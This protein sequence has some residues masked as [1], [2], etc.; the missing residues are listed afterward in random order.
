[1]AQNRLV[2][3]GAR[4][5]F[6]RRLGAR[7]AE[8][9][10]RNGMW[11]LPSASVDANGCLTFPELGTPIPEPNAIGLA[12]VRKIML[13]CDLHRRAGAIWTFEADAAT[14]EVGGIKLR[15][16]K[17]ADVAVAHEVFVERSYVFGMP[18]RFMFLDVGA[19]I[20]ASMLFLAKTYEAEVWGYE[21]VPSTAKIA[22][23]NLALNPE[24]A[25]HLVVHTYG[26]GESDME[27]E[28]ACDPNLR[29]SNSLFPSPGA[30]PPPVKS[31]ETISEKVIVKDV[32]PIVSEAL[33]KLGDRK[34]AVKLDAEGAEFGILRR[35]AA[36]DLLT[37]IDVLLLEWHRIPG[38]NVVELQELLTKSGFRW[39][40]RE[41][42]DAPVGFITAMR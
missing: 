18:G 5:V 14:I 22:E 31:A 42:H 7:W 6:L 33:A 10:S 30:A 35:L 21:L 24:L 19:N 1:V 25:A 27:T 2:E 41:H 28:L 13:A 15:I 26:L 17:E 4:L 8:P 36:A 11:R 20:G 3:L 23:Q 29:P 40:S 37:K 39:F 16:L 32:A 12:I 38:E 34:L 9:L